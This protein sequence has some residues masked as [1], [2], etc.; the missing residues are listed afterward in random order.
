MRNGVVIFLLAVLMIPALAQE[1][2]N[3]AALTETRVIGPFDKLKAGKGINVTLIESDVEKVVIHIVNATPEDVIT[4]L[5]GK[6]IV[7]KMKTMI[8]KGVAV[9]A[10]VHYKKLTEIHAG[11]GATIDSDAT[12]TAE[13]LTVIVGADALIEMDV[14]VKQLNA[15]LTAGR[16]E[17]TGDADAQQVVANTAARYNCGELKSKE[18]F[19]KVN[20]G[21]QATV[22][23]SDRISGTA[24]GGGK[25]YYTGNPAKVE[26]TESMGGKV[27]AL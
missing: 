13:K 27:Q 26:K 23:V 20:T 8:K 19:V 9:Q 24:G 25:I 7:L 12:F 14:D 1:P 15:E 11:G 3:A 22:N 5:E 6:T 21:G 10:Y 16:I 4:Q 18:A 2:S 17:L